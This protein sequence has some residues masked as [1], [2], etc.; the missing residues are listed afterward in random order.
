MSGYVAIFESAFDE[1]L[2]IDYNAIFKNELF[3]K[4]EL[5]LKLNQTFLVN[6]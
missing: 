6:E 5:H 2:K 3:D 4:I 1:I